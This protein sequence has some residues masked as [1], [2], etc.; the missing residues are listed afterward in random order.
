MN[1]DTLIGGMMIVT[2]A[3]SAVTG[4]AAAGGGETV[5]TGDSSASVQITNV[6]NANDEGGNAHTII[7]KTINGVTTITE[8][9]KDFAP[10]EPIEVNASAEARTEGSSTSQSATAPDDGS[11]QA[12]SGEASSTT[13][14]TAWSFGSYLVETIS[15]LFMGFWSLWS[16]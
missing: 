3:A 7:E 2:G 5:V 4:G 8:E 6:I 14:E 10:G 12:T 16:Q 13:Q 15:N 1:V 11:M 9:T